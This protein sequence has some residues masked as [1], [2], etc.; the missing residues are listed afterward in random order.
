MG[1]RFPGGADTPERYWQVLSEGVD[2]VK[3]I[4]PDRWDV[5]STFDPDP[6]VPGK[7]SIRHAGLLDRID[8]FDA[9]FF[10]TL[11]R[12]AERMD[13]QQRLF[14]EV[15]IDA[16]D[17][18]GLS[19][20]QLAGSRTGVCVASYHNDYTQMQ[21]ADLDWVDSRTL[22]GAPRTA[23]SRIACP[24]FWICAGRA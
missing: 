1:C 17:H 21:Y 16:L 24:T 22:T 11:P 18:A 14:M 19:R 7:S 23:L 10:G 15:S 20:E 6:A 5:A 4:P 13:P 3:E 12:E 9:G 2:T 8:M